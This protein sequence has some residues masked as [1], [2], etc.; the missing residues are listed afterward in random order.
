MKRKISIVCA[1][2]CLFFSLAS[3][4]YAEKTAI[5]R[6][7]TNIAEALTNLTDSLNL[8]DAI[9]TSKR[10]IDPSTHTTAVQAALNRIIDLSDEEMQNLEDRLAFLAGLSHEQDEQR[11]VHATKLADFRSHYETMRDAI[12]QDL[13][14]AELLKISN[15]LKKWHETDYVPAIAPIVDFSAVFQNKNIIATAARRLADI[16]KDE[17]RIKNA[18]SPSKEIIFVQLIKKAQAAIAQ[19]AKLNAEAEDALALPD[20]DDAIDVFVDNADM[21]IRQAYAHF[22]AMSKLLKK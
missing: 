6:E 4:A 1:T 22:I 13:S 10:P 7:N 16:M 21:L 11:N 14:L 18:L 2:A 20:A 9:K 8:L 15:R 19:A 12:N 5:P 17:K 3:Y